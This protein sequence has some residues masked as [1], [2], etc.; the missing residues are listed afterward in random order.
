MLIAMKR[1]PFRPNDA[2][3]S[4]SYDGTFANLAVST[5][6]LSVLSVKAADARIM[7]M[8]AT[9]PHCATAKGTPAIPA[10]RM[11]FERLAAAPR[12]VDRF[13][14]TLR[15]TFL[16]PP[17][18]VTITIGVDGEKNGDLGASC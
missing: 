14:S 4:V 8:P 18:V 16:D 3:A 7:K 10:P 6:I 2:S 17:G 12:I 13:S 11:S 9:K 5:R 15:F 1:K